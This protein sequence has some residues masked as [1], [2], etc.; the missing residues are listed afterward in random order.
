VCVKHFKVKELFY[1][2]CC[3]HSY[4]FI[5]SLKLKL[6]FLSFKVQNFFI[7]DL[8]LS[9]NYRL[10]KLIA[11]INDNKKFISFNLLIIEGIF[12]QIRI[13]YKYE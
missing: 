12:L 10:L 9:N 1:S 8:L 3:I 5:N 7:V 4:D 2:E 6:F 11:K 13:F